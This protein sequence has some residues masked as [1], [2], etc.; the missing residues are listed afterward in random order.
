METIVRESG[1]MFPTVR[2]FV[3]LPVHDLCMH[4]RTFEL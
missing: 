2:L 4:V 3:S 1:C